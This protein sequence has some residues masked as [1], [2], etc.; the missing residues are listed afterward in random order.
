MGPDQVLAAEAYAQAVE[1]IRAFL[2]R[3]GQATVSDLRQLL[4]CTR[5]IMVPLCEKL[6]KEGITR[7][8]GD[9]RKLGRNA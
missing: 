9:V 6:D 7:R 2:R 8:E 5:R 3:R 1:Q 4:G